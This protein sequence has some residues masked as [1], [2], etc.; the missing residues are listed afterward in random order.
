MTPREVLKLYEDNVRRIFPRSLRRRLGVSIR[1]TVLP[2]PTHPYSQRGKEEVL[3]ERFGRNTLTSV[4]KNHN[5]AIAAAVARRH[6]PGL[7]DK[8]RIFDTRQGRSH[9]LVE[10]LKASCC[11]PIYFD[12]P[13]KIGDTDYIDGGVGGN[14]PLAQ[15]IPRMKEIARLDEGLTSLHTVL[16]IAPPRKVRKEGKKGLTEWLA[17]FPLEMEDGYPVF[18]SQETLY[19]ETTFLRISP[20]SEETKRY[21]T[22]C[23]DINDMVESMR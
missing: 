11:A 5:E 15:A 14:C 23:W 22:D 8:L 13:T 3:E 6:H 19:P 17:W 12:G 20:Q 7:P 9:S 4:T 16:S 21:K 2:V 10:V 18:A 1:G